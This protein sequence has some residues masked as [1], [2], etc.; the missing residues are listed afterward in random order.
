M[1]LKIFF[2][3]NQ[4]CALFDKNIFFLKEQIMICAWI[5]NI[6]DNFEFVFLLKLISLSFYSQEHNGCNPILTQ[7]DPGLVSILIT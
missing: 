7:T 5:S 2:F 4:K 1:V 6:F 3:W